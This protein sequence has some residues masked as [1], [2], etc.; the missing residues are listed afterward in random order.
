MPLILSAVLGLLLSSVFIYFPVLSFSFASIPAVY[1]VFKKKYLYGF[2]V[3]IICLLG[4]S[5]GM[6]YS[7]VNN[8]NE[9][10][11]EFQG[12]VLDK[13]DNIY[14]LKSSKG[15]VFKL[16]Y[17]KELKNDRFYKVV[18]KISPEHRNPYTLVSNTRFCY[19][20]H[21]TD[22]GQLNLN[23]IQKIQQKINE[24]LKRRLNQNT[25]N[26]LVAMTTGHRFSISKEIQIDFQETGLIHLLSISGA[27]FSLLF[28]ASFLFFRFLLKRLPYK[29][30]VAITLYIKP[31]QLSILLCFP[32]VLIYFLIVEPNY[33]SARAFIMSMLFMFGVLT[34]RKSLWIIT[35]SIA[36][37]IILLLEPKS[38]G[39]LSFQLSFLATVGIGFVSDVYKNIKHKIPVKVLSYIFLSLLI[40]VSATLITAPLIVYRFHYLSLISPLSNLTAGFFIGMILFP[41]NILFI[42]IYFITETYPLPELINLIASVSFRLMHMLASLKF[43]SV[44][45]SAIPLGSVVLFYLAV[46]LAIF[47][48]YLLKGL[49]KKIVYCISSLTIIAVILISIFLT[50]GDNNKLKVT[51]ID[52]GQAEATIIETPQGFFL[53]DT[54]KTGFEAERFLK[55]KNVK[56]LQALIITHEQKDHAGGFE[57][58]IESFNVREIWDNGYIAYSKDFNA[59]IRHL[60]RGDILKIGQCSFTVL[61][62]YV[63]FWTSSLS[64][65]SNELGLIFKFKC[66]KNN[67]LFTSD[68]GVSALQ[69]IPV[70]YLKSEVI[71]IPHHGSK[72]SFY[73]EFYKATNPSICIIS[74]VKGNPYGH[75]HKEVLENIEKICKIY[76]TDEDGAIQI[77][78]SPEGEI[79]IQSF[80]DTMF[81]PYRELSNLKKLFVLW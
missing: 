31:S 34:E 25:S 52:V 64:K 10:I 69:S 40:S 23:F 81:E 67:Y 3:L 37:L 38:A 79:K 26:V 35:V 1:F 21:L 58:I 61:H 46:F 53:V 48:F 77:K 30:L 75:P 55:A 78:E 42:V 65:D 20:Q 29:I 24:E 12:Y 72:R 56:D 4:I 18:C 74:T 7:Q 27:H 39:D 5:Y 8:N 36:C 22:S 51:F 63:G 15:E 71:K 50:K 70:S 57:R 28:T 62:P 54:G 59:L 47:S 6:S 2:F 9:R 19:V 14:F 60:K 68:T 13:K 11:V 76:R 41:L 32:V 16:Y 73:P 44:N 33:P 17:E 49:F 66:F 43:S 80:K 45:I